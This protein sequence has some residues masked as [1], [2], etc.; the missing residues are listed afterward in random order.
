SVRSLASDNNRVRLELRV[1]DSG[2]GMTSEQAARLF[3]PFSQADNSTTRRYGGTG[4]GP[5][6]VRR[7]SEPVGGQASGER[8][9]GQRSTFTVTLDLALASRTTAP[10]ASRS[11]ERSGKVAGTVLAVDD[12]P[13]NLEVLKGQL[14]ILGV[15]VV[16][17]ANGLAALTKWREHPFALV[18]TDIHM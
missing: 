18:L 8:E 15:P 16:T 2:I 10:C 4:P 7:L 12:Y 11:V 17:A 9:A 14:E 6:S 1:A 5:F 3:Q 13:M